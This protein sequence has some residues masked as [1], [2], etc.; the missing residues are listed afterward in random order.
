MKYESI[1]KYTVMG[2]KYVRLDEL[3]QLIRNMKNKCREGTEPGYI[4]EN[5]NER[6]AAELSLNHLQVVLNKE[7]IAVETMMKVLRTRFEREARGEDTKVD[8]ASVEIAPDKENNGPYMV[9]MRRENATNKDGRY[10][11]LRSWDGGKP[12]IGLNGGMTFESE[13]VALYMTKKMRDIFGGEWK[14]VNVSPE[15]CEKA[16]RLLDA[17]FR[18]DE[19][20]EVPGWEGDGTKAEDEDWDG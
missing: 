12:V 15:E 2:N 19:D 4:S 13:N 5:K 20:D 6:I 7:E 8:M 10:I 18:D 1:S 9:C 11:F 14:V 17:I 16:R 3:N